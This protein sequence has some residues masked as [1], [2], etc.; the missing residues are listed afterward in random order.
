MENQK[1]CTKCGHEMTSDN[2]FCPKCGNRLETIKSKK[3]IIKIVII[4]VCVLATIFILLLALAFLME[5]IKNKVE[6]DYKLK[7]TLFNQELIKQTAKLM[8]VGSDVL[9]DTTDTISE[10]PLCSNEYNSKLGKIN[11]N[12]TTL[13]VENVLD[14][15]GILAS[16]E[17]NINNKKVVTFVMLNYTYSGWTWDDCEKTE[18][19]KFIKQQL[20]GKDI[21]LE[22][23][24]SSPTHDNQDYGIKLMHVGDIYYF[25]SMESAKVSLFRNMVVNGYIKEE[26]L[27][28]PFDQN[29]ADL[30]KAIELAKLENRGLW[31]LC[32]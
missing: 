5:S 10:F 7:K 23:R 18:A 15:G 1:N 13:H 9:I 19:R 20:F 24:G 32:R 11:E 30:I 14:D 25:D 28:M 6:G 22:R 21:Y 31:N 27:I 17:V 26:N 29:N 12:P 8:V 16:Y 4:T 2:Q 3:K